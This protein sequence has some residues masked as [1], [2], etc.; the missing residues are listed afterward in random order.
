MPNH[1]SEQ[2]LQDWKR[3]GY[4]ILSQA[5]KNPYF[6]DDE[7]KDLL[8]WTKE[9]EEWPETPGKW[10][11]YFEKSSKDNSRLLS[12]IE[13][14]FD[15]HEGFNQTFNTPKFLG[16]VSDLFGEPACLFKEKINMK[17]SGGAGFDPHQDV[18]AGWDMYGHTLHISML[19][20][21][22]QATE[23]NGCLEVV[24]G[25]HDKGLLGPMG[26]KIP[27]EVCQKLT[28][29]PLRTKPGDII[30]F[31]S[32]VPHRSG[33]NTSDVSRRLLYVTYNRISEGD[34][35][36]KYWADKRRNYPPDIERD[37]TKEYHYKI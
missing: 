11:K 13:N 2:Q 32:Y 35:R 31:D 23:T 10:M 17:L 30:F 4:L 21:L 1:L 3:D 24:A 18:Q 29:Q 37:P 28:W 34:F 25:Q 14:F 7:I 33:P 19:V 12:R 6:S 8:A 22:D 20:S 16:I 36:T 5:N 9:V 15:Y 26:S 27:D